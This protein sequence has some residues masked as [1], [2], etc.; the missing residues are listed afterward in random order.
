M[1]V[2]VET[3][4]MFDV[5]RRAGVPVVNLRGTVAREGIPYVSIDNLQV[6]TLALTHLRDRGLRNFAFCRRAET[7]N[8]ALIQ[9]GQHF[10]QLVERDGGICH[11]FSAPR[12]SV[13][14]GRVSCRADSGWEHEQQRLADWIASLPKPIGIMACNDE[15]GLHVLDACRRCDAIVPDDVA[16]IGVDN[17]QAICDLA[18]PP[19]TS[20]DVNAEAIGYEAAA[21]L[22]RMMAGESAPRTPIILPPRGVVT[23]RSSDIVA[24]DDEEASRALSYIRDHACRGLQVVDVLSHMVMSRASLQQRM[25]H[26]V[27]RTIHQEIQRVRLG[28]VKDLLSMSDLTIKQV[29]REGGFASVQYMTRVFRAMTGE[30]PAR[31]RARRTQATLK[32]VE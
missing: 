20:V 23:R 10:K 32:P 21:L 28:R 29:A 17:D 16:V 2:R 5:I 18:I 13:S 22:D 3:P 19:L 9:R 26:A 8:P 15:R 4:E 12:R 27:G 1:L 25:K 11:V 14:A 30:T 7:S 24:S 31:Y 6:A